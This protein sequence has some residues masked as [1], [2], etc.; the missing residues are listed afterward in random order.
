MI[1]KKDV[2]FIAKQF[3]RLLQMSAQKMELSDEEKMEVADLYPLWEVDKKYEMGVILKWGWNAD[4]ESQLWE[5]LQTHISQ[6]DW[7]PDKA[8]SLFKK[9]GFDEQSGYPIW[10]QPLGS[11]DAYQKGDIVVF[12]ENEKTY[13]STIDNNVWSPTAY[14]QGWKEI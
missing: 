5:V 11:S 1:E 10:T 9:I 2:M 13:E 12:E 3:N 6:A 14:P 8:V 7:T 4:N